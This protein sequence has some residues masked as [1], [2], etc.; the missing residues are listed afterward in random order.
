MNEHFMSYMKEDRIIT[1]NNKRA[2]LGEIS[3]EPNIIPNSIPSKY[4]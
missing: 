4:S 3:L 1:T 2:C